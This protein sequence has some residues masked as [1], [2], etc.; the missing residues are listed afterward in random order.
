MA[1]E[2]LEIAGYDELLWL[3]GGREQIPDAAMRIATAQNA[4][5]TGTLR[6][7]SGSVKLFNNPTVTPQALAKLGSHRFA[8]DVEAGVT[9]IYRDGSL[10]TIPATVT[11]NGTGQAAFAAA[12][13]H[14]GSQTF[15][16]GINVG[17]PFKIDPSGNVSKWGIA[18]PPDG[19]AVVAQDVINTLIEGFEGVIG[20]YTTKNGTWTSDGTNFTQ[21]S[22]SVNL[23]TGTTKSTFSIGLTTALNLAGQQPP[24]T[25]MDMITL[26]VLIDQPQN[27]RDI[28]LEFDL[29]T[30]Y[31]TDFYSVS[32]P[33]INLIAAN[34]YVRSTADLSS[35]D[36]LVA[37]FLLNPQFVP[38]P[39]IQTQLMADYYAGL[40]AFY[41]NAPHSFKTAPKLKPSIKSL[42]SFALALVSA[43]ATG[44]NQW[45]KLR[46][47]KAAFTRKGT[48]NAKT[49]ANVSG[50][51]IKLQNMA[52]AAGITSANTSVNFDNMTLEG[53][54]GM[55]GQF[56]YLVSF[57]NTVTGSYSQPN[58]TPATVTNVTRQEVVGNHV[59]VS[60]DPQVNA[61]YIWRTVGNGG[62]YYLAFIIPDNTTT[63]FIDQ[64]SDFIGLA[65]NQWV[66]NTAFAQNYFIQDSNGNT[67]QVTNVGGGTTGAT[68][69]VWA[70]TVGATTTDNTVTWTCQAL[71]QNAFVAAGTA[72]AI[73]NLS[74]EAL[75]Y[76]NI[77][78]NP[79][80][81]ALAVFGGTMFLCGDTAAGA[82]GRVYYSAVGY[83]EGVAGFTDVTNDTDP[84]M[85]F[86]VFNNNLYLF[87]QKGI[88]VAQ[89]LTQAPTFP[90]WTF[91][92]VSN[93]PG[94]SD[95]L[96]IQATE[97]GIIYRASDGLRLFTGYDAPIICSQILPLFRGETLEG[98]S[99][100]AIGSIVASALG[101]NEYWLSDGSKTF[102][103]SLKPPTNSTETDTFLVRN[104]G[105]AV[106]ALNY[107]DDTGLMIAGASNAWI[108]LEDP[109]TYTDFDGAITVDWM[110]KF[111]YSGEKFEYKI[112]RV[113]IDCNMHGNSLT[114]NVWQDNASAAHP[115]AVTNNARGILE[116]DWNGSGGHLI[117]VELT[118]TVTSLVE[119]FRI[120]IEVDTVKTNDGQRTSRV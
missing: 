106:Q 92:Q 44:T 8:V 103:V 74:L 13:P 54:T 27:V 104:V 79:T 1:S 24:S 108:S 57:A 50:W 46:I 65:P 39:S 68:P 15:L 21:G 60:T 63:A 82:R 110:P 111:F 89:D 47:P 109:S 7:R 22:K 116:F 17:T 2:L 93:I 86:G 10:L 99:P 33:V 19:M 45:W 58:P 5:R 35:L 52:T 38:T 105:R 85:G 6:S 55:F 77:L 9:K 69:P 11:L 25:D 114:L 95:A 84:T 87:T 56:N 94:T 96:S 98:V 61:R 37:Q 51:Q 78:P 36:A 32:I 14:F 102:A 3:I 41:K 43:I 100:F 34:N 42:L 26:D 72:T 49:W 113:F 40:Q 64:I 16:F 30:N 71:G 53:G 90:A 48:N 80:V 115:Q 83:I 112:Q 31:T 4:L 120:L 97:V 107:E 28:T 101:R 76:V 88:F 73:G 12:V 117:G 23:A 118:G 29:G 81:S 67:Q 75:L 70:T 59:P 119:I 20:S 66:A 91:V 62:L 18:A